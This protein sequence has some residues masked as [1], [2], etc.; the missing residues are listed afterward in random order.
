VAGDYLG[1]AKQGAYNAAGATQQKA[2]D[3]A[4]QAGAVAGDKWEQ[5]KQASSDASQVASDKAGSLAQQTRDA[6][7][8]AFSSIKSDVTPKQQQR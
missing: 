7:N 3:L 5:T 2:G 6:M 8:T 1:Q 4:N